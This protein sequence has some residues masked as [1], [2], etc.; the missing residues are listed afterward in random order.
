MAN[1][2]NYNEKTIIHLL[3]KFNRVHLLK[4][5]LGNTFNYLLKQL[6]DPIII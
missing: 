1:Y 4:H 3:I 5:L 2:I 6:N